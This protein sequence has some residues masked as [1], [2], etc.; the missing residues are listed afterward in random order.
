M[1][2]LVLFP[3]TH[4]SLESVLSLDA[5][6][7]PFLWCPLSFC[8]PY[9]DKFQK[10][11][12]KIVNLQTWRDTLQKSCYIETMVSFF[13]GDIVAYCFYLHGVPQ[14]NKINGQETQQIDINKEWMGL[15]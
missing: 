10:R 1:L 7:N 6:N 4:A 13:W 12:I 2:G 11:T 9:S 14:L 3:E 15:G 8:G 5:K